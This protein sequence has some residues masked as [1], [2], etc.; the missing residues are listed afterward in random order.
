MYRLEEV[1]GSDR[2]WQ[3]VRPDGSVAFTMTEND[4]RFAEQILGAL[5]DGV[6]LSPEDND[7]DLAD[8]A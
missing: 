2:P 8:A 4:R 1:D 3:V 7:D 5:N 6:T